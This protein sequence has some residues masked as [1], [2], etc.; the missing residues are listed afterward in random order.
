VGQQVGH[1][2]PTLPCCSVYTAEQFSEGSKSKYAK[3]GDLYQRATLFKSHGCG[4]DHKGTADISLKFSK[5]LGKD[6]NINIKP[7]LSAL[8]IIKWNA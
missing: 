3:D 1:N 5:S 8:F 2:V 7:H 6:T 4:T